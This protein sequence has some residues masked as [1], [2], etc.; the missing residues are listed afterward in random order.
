[1]FVSN[2]VVFLPVLAA[3]ADV[4]VNNKPLITG[5]ANAGTNLPPIYVHPTKPTPAPGAADP[6][7]LPFPY[8]ATANKSFDGFSGMSLD[9]LK[10]MAADWERSKLRAAHALNQTSVK[11]GLIIIGKTIGNYFDYWNPDAGQ[12]LGLG[13]LSVDLDTFWTFQPATLVIQVVMGEF[14]KE[15][16]ALFNLESEKYVAAIDDTAEFHWSRNALHFSAIRVML[17]GFLRY[18]APNVAGVKFYYGSEWTEEQESG[19]YTVFRLMNWYN[20]HVFQKYADGCNV[21]ANGTFVASIACEN[22]I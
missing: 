3:L 17:S 16:R 18:I 5:A 4:D 13:D 10:F 12:M 7:L 14:D 8:S 21:R 15:M 20:W 9:Q 22:C 6:R 1:M 2:V 19:Y 11:E